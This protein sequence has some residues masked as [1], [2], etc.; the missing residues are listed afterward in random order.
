M[1]LDRFRNRVDALERVCQGDL[2]RSTLFSARSSVLL[3]L[4]V[5]IPTVMRNG[6]IIW[7]PAI[8]G[9]GLASGSVFTPSIKGC[10]A[11]EAVRTCR[12]AD[13][14]YVGL[15]TD[16]SAWADRMGARCATESRHLSGQAS[17]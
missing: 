12:A 11:A 5:T 1:S 13:R 6:T 8:Y 14:Q 17:D 2:K 10:A 7:S 15:S 4:R 9:V 16:I 3:A